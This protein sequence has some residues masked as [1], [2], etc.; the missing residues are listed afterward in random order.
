MPASNV[1]SGP[2]KHQLSL[3]WLCFLACVCVHACVHV[4]VCACVC[5]CARAHACVC[6]CVKKKTQRLKSLKFHVYWSFLINTVAVKELNSC[7]KAES[8]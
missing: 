3:L 2:I 5:M 8:P 4:C 7:V 6:V 1:F